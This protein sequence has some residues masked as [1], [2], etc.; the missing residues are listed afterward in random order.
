MTTPDA[1]RRASDANEVGEAFTSRREG[2]CGQLDALR[3]PEGGWLDLVFEGAPALGF[4]GRGTV[5][6]VIDTGL[7]IG[8]PRLDSAVIDRVDLSGE[9]LGDTCGHGTVVALNLLSVAPDTRLID[10]KAL[11]RGGRTTAALLIAALRWVG[12]RGGVTTVNMSAGLYRPW[13]AGDCDLCQAA[14]AL[15]AA[16]PAI[17]AA[18]GNRA[19]LTACP[20]KAENVFSITAID[21]DGNLARG[22][23]DAGVDGFAQRLPSA[24]VEPFGPDEAAPRL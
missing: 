15:A 7:A 18:A 24:R 4:T 14:N 22:A 19:G 21:G 8:H 5:T 9:G 17:V 3:T 12:E 10:V 16:G 11:T 23:G 2:P 1:Q 20:A 13:C 6:A